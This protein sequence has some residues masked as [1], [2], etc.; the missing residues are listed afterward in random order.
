[1]PDLMKK[2]KLCF[3]DR[4]CLM[5]LGNMDY[6]DD[7]SGAILSENI[8]GRLKGYGEVAFAHDVINAGTRPEGFIG[9]I[10]EKGFDHLIFLDAVEFGGAP[11]SVVFLNAEEMAD[12]FP[13]I[14]THRISLGL[15][16]KWA[17]EEGTTNTWLL[18]VQPGSLKAGQGLT[19]EVSVT[20]EILEDL[21]YDLC[22]SGN[23]VTSC[24]F[25]PV[26]RQENKQEAII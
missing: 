21:L 6:G 10:V 11:G 22:I 7:G 4:V 8:A 14:S 24:G 3:R 5:G 13:Q 9:S 2:L 15:L 20:L 25:T 17:E 18:G 23:S 19:P 16:A 1:M 26:A 12:R